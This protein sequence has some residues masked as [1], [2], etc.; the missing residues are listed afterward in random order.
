MPSR[1]GVL[2][3]NDVIGGPWK[4]SDNGMHRRKEEELNWDDIFRKRPKKIV[5]YKA[6]S[7]SPIKKQE[8]ENPRKG[9]GTEYVEHGGNRDIPSPRSRVSELDSLRD[10]EHDVSY[11]SEL[12]N[13]VYTHSSSQQKASDNQVKKKGDKKNAVLE[14]GREK[15][16]RGYKYK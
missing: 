1:T 8:D 12:C 9:S 14:D 13:N 4:C 6:L 5:Y 10:D 7:P 16:R 2:I 15:K 3:D 11:M